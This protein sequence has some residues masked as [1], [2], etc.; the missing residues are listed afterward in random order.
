MLPLLLKGIAKKVT[1]PA[2]PRQGINP[3]IPIGIGTGVVALAY[4]KIVR[5]WWE[6]HKSKDQLK[7]NQASTIKPAP[8]KVLKDLN[9]KPITSANL[10]TI[11]ADL[12][13]ALSFPADGPRA[14]RVFKSTPWGYVQKLEDLYLENYHENLKDLLA[15]KLSD[16]EWISIKFNFK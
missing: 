6:E 14:V 10:S 11:A 1:G 15:K 16:S 5:P 8:G 7:K 13:E 3:L 2:A 12:K 4:W 9:G